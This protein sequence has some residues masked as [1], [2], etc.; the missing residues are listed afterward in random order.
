MIAAL[1]P[2]QPVRKTCVLN[3]RLVVMG[4]DADTVEY[5]ALQLC[6]SAISAH[7]LVEHT[8]PCV[9][10]GFVIDAISSIKYSSCHGRLSQWTDPSKNEVVQEPGSGAL[11]RCAWAV[12][13]RPTPS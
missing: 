13:L 3:A 8:A 4:C 11:L 2:S 6:H 12:M 10:T 7:S 1:I 9:D 5:S